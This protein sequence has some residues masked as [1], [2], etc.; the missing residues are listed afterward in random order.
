MTTQP[1]TGDVICLTSLSI[2]HNAGV[3]MSD[4]PTL[5]FLAG[6]GLHICHIFHQAY[7]YYTK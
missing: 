5:T 6:T 2:H 4:S 3:D 1:Q 7:F